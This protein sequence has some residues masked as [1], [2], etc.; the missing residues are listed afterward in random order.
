MNIE[1][2]GVMLLLLNMRI[3]LFLLS[4]HERESYLKTDL[5]SI[6]LIA[7]PIERY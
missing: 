4:I 5:S 2:V 1:T 3:F 6:V 7:M